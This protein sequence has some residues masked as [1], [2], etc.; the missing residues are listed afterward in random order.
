MQKVARIGDD[1]VNLPG[2][3]LMGLSAFYDNSSSD[4][5]L[6]VIK[7]AY[8]IGCRFWDTADVY[9]RPCTHGDNEKLVAAAMKKYD[10][11]RKDL[12]ICTK[13]A[14]SFTETG[15][16]INGSPD[17]AKL[18][19]DRSLKN[20]EL[21]FVDL[22]YLHRVDPNVPIEESAKA[23]E[24]LRKA[25]KTRYIG[26]SECTA[27]QLR[28]A[29]KVAKI[30]A[31]QR[32][33]SLFDT[34]AEESGLYDACQELGVAFVAYS[35]LSRGF[36][37]GTIKSPDDF[38]E[39]DFRRFLPRFSPEN[40]GYNLHL[41]NKITEIA[42]M[43]GIMPAQLALAWTIHKGTLPIPGTTKIKRLEEN[44]EAGRVNISEEELNAITD[45]LNQFTI[46]GDRYPDAAMSG[47]DR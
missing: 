7:K 41:V 11:P 18:A 34:T 26:I 32:E 29:C 3:G 8:D 28:R 33:Y 25:G 17:Y 22:Y 19:L 16:T 40:F 46:H 24:E 27:D 36:L 39:K 35:P 13:F 43:K 20:L 10:I 6:L 21:D 14:G 5:P 23:L 15:M 47:V 44:F 9:S 38:S 12:F 45:I 31:V 37:S 2:L 4:D 42:K 30:D 1:E